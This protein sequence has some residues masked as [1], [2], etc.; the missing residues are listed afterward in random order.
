MCMSV[1]TYIMVIK[2]YLHVFLFLIK[3]FFFFFFCNN[4]LSEIII[5]I[6]K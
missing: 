1:S 5:N 4:K 6:V 3:A 2:K